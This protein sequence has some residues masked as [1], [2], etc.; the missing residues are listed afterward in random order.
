MVFARSAYQLWAFLQVPASYKN[1]VGLGCAK[2]V[3]GKAG[4]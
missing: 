4:G 1:D 3:A 2:I